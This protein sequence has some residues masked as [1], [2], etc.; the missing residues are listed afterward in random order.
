MASEAGNQS[1]KSGSQH[2]LAQKLDVLGWGLFFIWGGIAL[3]QDFG[4]GVGLI[5]VAVIVL[6]VQGLRRYFGMWIQGF[7]VVVG[8]LFLLGGIWELWGFRFSTPLLLIVVGAAL[9]ASIFLGM[10]RHHD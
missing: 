10:H 3:L 9:L 1:S 2:V 6:G 7:W 8:V 4:W 5:G